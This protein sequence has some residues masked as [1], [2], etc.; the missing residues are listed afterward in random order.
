MNYRLRLLHALT[1][2]ARRKVRRQCGLS[3]SK[4]FA[5]VHPFDLV[6]TQTIIMPP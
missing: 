2:I 4:A 6:G 5:Q 1:S 3:L